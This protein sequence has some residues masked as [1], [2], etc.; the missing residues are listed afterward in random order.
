M[1]SD[2]P[3]FIVAWESVAHHGQLKVPAASSPIVKLHNQLVTFSNVILLDYESNP[4]ERA[5]SVV[6]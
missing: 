3:G 5:D 6:N 1:S 2:C 4:T